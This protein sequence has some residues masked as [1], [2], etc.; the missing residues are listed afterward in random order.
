MKALTLWQPWAT[1]M[2]YGLKTIE[3]RSWPTSYRGPLAIHAGTSREGIEWVRREQGRNDDADLILSAIRRR[4]DSL[5]TLPRGAVVCIVD[6]YDCKPTFLLATVS[7]AERAFGNFS[8]GR[9]GILTR[10]VNRLLVLVP[11][12]GKQGLWEWSPPE[13]R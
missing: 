3:T 5:A 6:V 9:Y 13:P 2:A 10:N 11:A 8:P 4:G 12:K 1:L 7:Y